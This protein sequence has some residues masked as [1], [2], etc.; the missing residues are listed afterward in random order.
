VNPI[1][2]KKMKA[3]L[4]TK[5]GPPDLLKL[6]NVEIPT[7]KDD[8]VLVKVYATTVNRTDCALIRA[9]PFFTRI[10]T[11]MFKPKHNMTGTEFAGKVEKVGKKVTSFRVGD[12]VFGMAEGSYG[13]HAQYMTIRQDKA[14]V[15]MP[16]ELTYEQAAACCEGPF[17]AYNFINKVKV[18]KGTKVL[19][20]GATGGI[21]SAAVQ[22]ARNK[23]AEVDAVCRGKHFDIVRSLGARKLFD[24]TKEDFTKSGKVY[25]H[26]FDTVGKSTFSKCK[27]LIKPGGSYISSELGP[28]S[29]N[30]FLALLTP[31]VGKKK[32]KFPYPRD[33]RG[34]IKMIRKLVQNGKY[35]PVIDRKYPFEQIVDVF[36]Y[37]EKGQKVGNVV[38]TINHSTE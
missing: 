33:C 38:I 29:Q 19:V 1:D 2:R 30:I 16:K 14:V 12:R 7:P 23:G 35:R 20:N 15:K 26:V 24:Y 9:I 31:L 4:W 34:T 21:G 10:I 3:V 37:V 8:E 27:P 17:Y 32:V 28:G 25:D 36:K 5:Y 6:K 22:L 11:G 13:A 18:R